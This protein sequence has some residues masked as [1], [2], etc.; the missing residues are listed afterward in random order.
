M[1][2]KRKQLI[3]LVDDESAI[4][5]FFKFKLE[6][7]SYGVITAENGKEA[8]SILDDSSIDLVLT[9]LVMPVM[10]GLELLE[11]VT[12]EY[13]TVPVIII[14]GV[15]D[16]EKIVRAIQ[17]GAVNFL[18]KPVNHE[19]LSTIVEKGLNR[20]IQLLKEAKQAER[21]AAISE[22]V[23]RI[24]QRCKYYE[25]C[26][27]VPVGTAR[28]MDSLIETLLQIWKQSAL[29]GGF[30]G[31]M[32]NFPLLASELLSNCISYGR[33]GVSSTLRDTE[34][35]FDRSFENAV[36][37]RIINKADET[38]S[39]LFFVTH[40]QFRVVIKDYGDGFNWRELPDNILDVLEKPHGRGVLLMR[41]IGAE[42][43]WNDVGNEVTL[44]LRADGSGDGQAV[45]N[46]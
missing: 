36:D 23:S 11:R 13:P 7:A 34:D 38:M 1:T 22:Y 4:R 6:R 40:D 35:P 33:L 15:G 32:K 8:L 44:T 25:A 21:D 16:P 31:E 42:L 3:L 19:V 43:S 30:R 9:D 2:E 10:D 17:A 27:E 5:E 28:D 14:S 12:R 24:S 39:V 18:P 20:R 29:Y 45:R 46:D 41:S 26:Y 37:E